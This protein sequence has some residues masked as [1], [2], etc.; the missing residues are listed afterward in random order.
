MTRLQLQAGLHSSTTRGW[1]WETSGYGGLFCP[2]Y[3]VLQYH[4]YT[5]F[6]PHYFG[7]VGKTVLLQPWAPFW[8]A[9]CLGVGVAAYPWQ[10]LLSACYSQGSTRVERIEE[11][12]GK[13]RLPH[14]AGAVEAENSIGG[15]GTSSLAT[16]PLCIHLT[17]RMSG[18][19][20]HPGT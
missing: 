14:L 13:M 7:G 16:W 3:K 5:D 2:S 15:K 8:K 19:W 12:Q 6:P 4:C 9:P 1:W 10:D 18:L 11:I 20:E 17:S